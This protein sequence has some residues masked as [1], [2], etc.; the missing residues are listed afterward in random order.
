MKFKISPLYKVL[1]FSLLFVVGLTLVF[2]GPLST[3]SGKQITLLQTSDMHSRI[4]P[5]SASASDK[6]A[7]LSGIVRR[8]TLVNQIRQETPN[9][10]LLDC[11][12]FSQGTPYY[13][14]FQG[15]LEVKMMNHMGYD[16]VAI[17]NHE[18]DFGID[19]LAKLCKEATF[20]VVCAN[21]QVDG[22]PLE[23]LVDRYTV[24]ERDGVRVGVFGISPPLEGLVQA[25]KYTGVTYLDPVKS[26]NQTAAWLKGE[27]DCD[28]I[29]CLSHL[30][31]H[32]DK[33]TLIP[34]TRGIDVVLGGHSHTLQTEHSSI[35]NELGVPVALRHSGSSGIYVARTDIT[36]P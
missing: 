7:G 31:Y 10:I 20:A 3:P 21:Y 24:I 27:L 29:V 6:N 14:L 2:S 19:N 25:S 17:G 35:L 26:A 23:G 12:D 36:L 11:G 5:I 28:L 22:T 15:E 1:A 4:D 8:S 18:F 34:Q 9:V 32:T 13:N 16:A 33:N 30:G